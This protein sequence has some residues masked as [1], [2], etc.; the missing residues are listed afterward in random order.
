ME[1]T[2]PSLREQPAQ[3]IPAEISV[4][5]QSEQ[6]VP[7]PEQGS[8]SIQAPSST[9]E[10]Q[11]QQ[12]SPE[13][14]KPLYNPAEVEQI[15]GHLTSGIFDPE[16][17]LLFGKLVGGT[18]FSDP[19]A[20]DLLMVVRETPSYD[21]IQAKRYLRY[22]MP[23]RHREITYI[24]IYIQPLNYVEGNNSPFLYFTH[25]EG[26]LIYC[27]DRHYFHPKKL[28]NFAAA[29]CDAKFHFDTFSELGMLYLEKAY[30]EYVEGRKLR[31]AALFTA[32]AAIYFYH[33][34]YYVYHGYEFDIHDPVVMHERMR[35]L[36]AE[37]MLVLD[38]NH[39]DYNFTLP[40][41]K[42]FMQKA[43]YNLN[44]D[45]APKELEM[46]MARVEKMGDIIQRLCEMRLELYEERRE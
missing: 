24:N 32:Q 36:S 15:V 39:I 44:F 27:K 30:S 37:L 3:L 25:N 28:C 31:P 19:M 40:C 34:L 42:G 23:L 45:V 1:T 5:N 10:Q 2:Q 20:Y 14:A 46:H 7:E 13:P 35:T 11:P 38:D 6:P 16:Y 18:R 43:A 12:A 9:P 26:K 8:A 21:W 22:Q 41:L 33:T 29:Y 17:I 4:N